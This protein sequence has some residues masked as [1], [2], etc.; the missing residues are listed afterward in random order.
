MLPYVI[1]LSILAVVII[2]F[3]LIL[4]GKGKI[5]IKT[6]LGEMRVEGDNTQLPQSNSSIVRV[7]DAKAGRDL[8][9]HSAGKAE[10]DIQQVTSK[11][12]IN[13][14]QTPG[15]PPRKK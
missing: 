2:A 11:R 12:D 14:S 9:V 7:K 15:V 5:W 4:R 13:V 1:G 6:L 3:F 10:I 8:T